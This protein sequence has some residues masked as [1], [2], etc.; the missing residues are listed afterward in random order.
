MKSRVFP[1]PRWSR[2]EESNLQR[3]DYYTTALPLELRQQDGGCS[4]AGFRLYT[5]PIKFLHPLM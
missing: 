5:R 2:R 4:T 3:V 1:A